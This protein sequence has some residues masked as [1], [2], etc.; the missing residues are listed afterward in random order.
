[1]DVNRLFLSFEGRIGR[2]QFWMGVIV[3]TAIELLLNWMLG[4][5]IASDPVDFRQRLIQFVIGLVALYPTIAIAVKR[6]HDRGRPGFYVAW[7]LAAL[8]IF[9]VGSLYGYFDSSAPTG[10]VRAM[11]I[12]FVGLVTLAFLIELG[13]RRGDPGP[14]QYGPQPS[15]RGET[16]KT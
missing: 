14:N 16:G 15:S 7:L 10:F 11:V 13:F 1:M 2:R 8:A 3:V 5:P 4:V 6:L 9:V 12:G